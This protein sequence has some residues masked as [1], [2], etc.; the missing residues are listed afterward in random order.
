MFNPARFAKAAVIT[1]SLAGMLSLGAA[2]AQARRYE[3]NCRQRVAK[4][5]AI[6]RKRSANTDH[7]AAR[8]SSVA[9]SLSG[10]A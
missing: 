8:P 4:A 5:E 2:P 10:R 1:L 9:S 7:A 6:F 3:K